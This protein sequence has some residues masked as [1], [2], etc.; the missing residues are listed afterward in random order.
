MRSTQGTRAR[1]SAPQAVDVTVLGLA[2]IQV[3]G[4]ACTGNVGAGGAASDVP[5]GGRAPRGSGGAGGGAAAEPPC[6]E[7]TIAPRVWRLTPT[8]LRNTL[9]EGLGLRDVDTARLPADAVDPHTG[10]V[11][12]AGR[13][14]IGGTMSSALFDLA[15]DAAGKWIARLSGEDACV[16]T[17][18]PSAECVDRFVASVG[19]RAFRRP[20]DVEEV[21]RYAAL[22]AGARGEQGTRGAAE[23]VVHAML[24]SPDFLYRTELGSAAD[25]TELTDYELASALSYGIADRPPDAALLEAAE[26]GDLRDGARRA[27]LALAL[28]NE[29]GAH[30]KLAD[31]VYWQLGLHQLE[32]KADAIGEARVR[33]LSR[34]SVRFVSDLLA[35]ETP[36]LHALYTASHSFVD[37]PLAEIYGVSPGE[38]RVELPETERFG[39]F[40]Q[41]GW[42]TAARD[43]IHRGR[44]LREHFLCQGIP[45]LP[46][47]A[48]DLITQLPASP[49]DATEMEKWRIFQ[50]E[51][52][53]CAACHAL[54]QPLGLAFETYDVQG[55]YRTQNEHGRAIETASRISDAEGWSGQF[56]DARDLAEQLAG[57]A[58]G[59]VCF[60]ARYLTFAMGQAVDGT[61]QGCLAREVGRKLAREGLDLR[62][63]AAAL[64]EHPVFVERR[65]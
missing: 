26:R 30:A 39:I 36:T 34:E 42:L 14:F 28:A 4:V 40:T 15:G 3:L 21:A 65:R 17:S 58:A 23:L 49:P 53:G 43:S 55:R 25:T 60:A 56:R 22:F 48:G 33:S 11:N 35:S 41:P 6:I 47:D 13:T 8:Q 52:A 5:A 32:A 46:E 50:A 20:L 10:F 38:A 7:E 61:G 27:A 19:R 64:V 1:S 63:L 29:P 18:A 37:G 51:R 62:V 59:Q 57:S 24:M 45:P 2:V 12:G 31:L 54:F 44:I 16:A 9:T